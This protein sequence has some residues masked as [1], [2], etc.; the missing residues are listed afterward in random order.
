MSW[1][2]VVVVALSALCLALVAPSIFARFPTAYTGAHVQGFKVTSVDA[3]SPAERA[4]LRP[5]DLIGCIDTRDH[6][7]LTLPFHQT[8][9]EPD[10]IHLCITNTVPSRDLAFAAVRGLQSSSFYGNTAMQVLRLFSYV[11]FLFV[12]CA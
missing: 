8:A 10:L 7:I 3:G 4:G 12:G 9:Y 5:G 2:A 6:A 1:R 11:V